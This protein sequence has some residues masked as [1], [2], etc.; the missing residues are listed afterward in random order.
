MLYIKYYTK[1][2]SRL[3]IGLRAIHVHKLSDEAL[4][5]GS[6]YDLQIAVAVS[7]DGSINS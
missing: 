5:T 7:V 2:L 6:V 3:N 1:L 4:D